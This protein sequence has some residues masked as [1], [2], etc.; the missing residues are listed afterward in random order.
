MAEGATQM[1]QSTE[2]VIVQGIAA[3][4]LHEDQARPVAVSMQGEVDLQHLL[5]LDVRLAAVIA[6]RP[7]PDD[8][9]PQFEDLLEDLR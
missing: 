2:G 3:E 7:L 6:P 8:F 1:L 5:L 4:V 9:I